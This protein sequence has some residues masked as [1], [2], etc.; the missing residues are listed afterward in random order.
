MRVKIK[1]SDIYRY[2]LDK[3]FNGAPYE[4]EFEGEPV[5]TISGCCGVCKCP[6]PRLVGCVCHDTKCPCHQSKNTP[7]LPE[8]VMYDKGY[9]LDASKVA[10]KLN[11]IIDYLQHHVTEK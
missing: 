11:E 3:T 1:K 8:K 5:E 2:F 7:K 6:E 10:N 9:G 4:I